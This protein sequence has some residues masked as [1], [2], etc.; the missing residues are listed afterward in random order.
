MGRRR[1]E[2]RANFRFNTVRGPFPELS[3]FLA[4]FPWWA[5]LRPMFDTHIIRV[6]EEMKDG[7]YEVRA[8][9]PGVDPAKDVGVTVRDGGLTI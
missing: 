7:N 6:E 8:E 9:I 1:E 4:G 3:E 2:S 5:G